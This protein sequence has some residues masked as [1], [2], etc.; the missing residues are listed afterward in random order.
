[1]NT[2]NA[3]DNGREWFEYKAVFEGDGGE[4][5]VGTTTEEFVRY[6]KDRPKKDLTNFIFTP[7]YDRDVIPELGPIAGEWSD[8]SNL[9]HVN[10]PYVN[11]LKLSIYEGDARYPSFSYSR[12]L[13]RDTFNPVVTTDFRSKKLRRETN[14][15]KVQAHEYQTVG[16]EISTDK[17]F[18]PKYLRVTE[19]MIDGLSFLG[20]VSYNDNELD[21]NH[22]DVD[23]SGRTSNIIFKKA[24]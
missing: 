2:N 14:M 15:L 8:F 9:A 4:A 17:P 3:N 1:M 22:W 13:F 12:E 10:G 21:W 19:D 6:W 7:E 16:F 20:S 18:D 24:G 11:A 5:V 23:Y